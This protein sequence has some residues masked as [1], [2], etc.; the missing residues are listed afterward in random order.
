V[1]IPA[2]QQN[3]SD[4]VEG[5]EKWGSRGG[6][7]GKVLPEA[8]MRAEEPAPESKPALTIEDL[9]PPSRPPG[10]GNSFSLGATEETRLDRFKRVFVD[11]MRR[12]GYVEQQ[13]EKSLGITIPRAFKP[14]EYAA[15]FEGRAQERLDQLEKKHNAP[16]REWITKS[17][18][19][20]NQIDHYLLA[21]AAPDRNAKVLVR[22]PKN[23]A[24]SGITNER[25]EEILAQFDSDGVLPQ[26]EQLGKMVDALVKD[27][28]DMRVESGLMTRGEADYLLKMEPH[29]VPLKGVAAG[30]DLSVPGDPEPHIG[31]AGRGASVSPKEYKVAKGRSTLPFSPLANVM[32]DATVAII[33]GERNVVGQSFLK[34][35]RSYP[36]DAWQIF[37]EGNPERTS[38]G[39]AI[40]MGMMADRYLVVKEDGKTNFIKINDPLLKRAVMNLGTQE[41]S[42]F[43]RALGK[44]IGVA[45][46]ALSRSYTTLNPEF[47][48][49]NYL[50]DIEAATFNILAE[51]DRVDGRL[52]GKKILKGVL[53]D[54]S[55]FKD[56]VPILRATIDKAPRTPEEKATFELFQQFKSDGGTTGWIMRETPKEVMEKIK[57]EIDRATAK[58]GKRGI[59]ATQDGL[60][61]IIEGVENFN[62]TFENVTR[63]AVYKHAI[64]AKLSRN[65]AASMARNVTVDFNRKGEVGPT[66]NA[67]YAFFNASVQGNVQLVRSL[68]SDPRKHGGLTRAQYLALG[69]VTLGAIQSIMNNA[70]S[71]D[72]EDG[73]SFYDKI[74][75]HEKDRNLIFMYNGREYVKI[76]LAYGY[77]LFHSLGS[78]ASEMLGGK[79]EVGDFALKMMAGAINNFA[80]LSLS[81]ETIPGLLSSM[82]P[83]VAK[84]FLDLYRNENFFGSKIYNSPFDE[85]QSKS[86]V[87]RYSTPEAYKAIAEFMNN[88][89]GGQGKIAGKVDFP[90]EGYEY[91]TQFAIGGAGQFIG[92]TYDFATEGSETA[93]DVPLGRKIFGEP[94]KYA[95]LG[96]FYDRANEMKPIIKQIESSDPA[97]R[98]AL[99]DKYPTETNSRVVEAMK[100][101]EK[102]VREI[103][104]QRKAL[105]NN[106]NIEDAVRMERKA[107]LDELQRDAY[108]RFNKIYNQVEGK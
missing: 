40:P 55:S 65:D 91:L 48:I 88:V 69:M 47:A 93:A 14:T 37:S 100:V 79:M 56:F 57:S 77:S 44:T 5:M 108:I 58:G 27:M 87:S 64:D 54:T 51:Q 99:R 11:R 45:T 60:K 97:E 19:T 67:L 89:T 43:N 63:F 107:R 7:G 106:E 2:D 104:K 41:W 9:L 82:V 35:A 84:P 78:N 34:L 86:S 17:G 52:A 71:D 4:I 83:T 24:G 33:R 18:L 61:K 76:P 92:R 16:I 31:Y 22:D 12:M 39:N 10:A 23:P 13:I 68:G 29:Y 103:N 90:A 96:D 94:S 30:G 49:P 6:I 26:L 75:D 20:P 53:K 85:E 70:I 62:S 50:R 105:A 46:R 102:R 95:D 21:R 42:A 32:S 80:P 28:L 25:A 72:D 81:G 36:S 74:P 66:L 1:L 73:K 59:Y 38:D 101:A 98:K 3:V 15:R 8:E